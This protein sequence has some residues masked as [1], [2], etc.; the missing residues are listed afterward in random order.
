M[1]ASGKSDGPVVPLSPTNNGETE[2]PAESAEGRGPA[3]RNADQSNLDRTQR[4]EHRRSRGLL[5]VREAARKSRELKFTALLHHLTPELLE[6]SFYELRKNAAVGVDGVTWH[7]YER[8]LEERL[9][10]LHGRI[11]RGAFRATPSKRVYIAKPDGRKRPL[12][13]PSL[14]DKIVQ[15]AVRTVLQCIYEEEFLGFSYGFRPQRSQH[16][17][18]DALYVAITEKRVNWILDAD[19]EGFFDNINRDWLVKFIEHRVGDKRIVRL[20]QKWL[21]AGIIEGT[22]WS[23]N[24]K[25]TPQG[26][27]LSPLLAN[28]FLHYVFD[29]WINQWRS[30]HA[31]GAVTV[32]RYADDF[33]IGFEREADARACWEALA[34]RLSQF[35]LHLHPTK[36]RLIEFGRRSA[37]RREREGQGKCE[38]FDFLGFTHACGKTRRG[39]FALKRITMASRMRRTLAALKV[40]LERCR[41]DPV[42]Q[43]GRWLTSVV[44]GWQGYHAVPDNYARLEQFDKAVTKLWRRQLQ[45]R[46]QR[47]NTRWPW[48]RLSRLIRTYLPRPRILH[49]RP[50]IRHHARLEARAV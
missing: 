27:V 44:R 6:A 35:G 13:I 21:N 37:A 43:V 32:I 48:T 33:V 45:R 10:D 12:G 34:E 36:T 22:D 28:V 42:G 30:R 29:L 8:D 46:S 31:K 47:G 39:W 19:I 23:D 38:T 2:S 50:N 26:A 18:L 5:G 11:H 1:N 49:P 17:A 25:G 15:H 16:Q 41:H 14:E 9:V 7:E 3:R 20:I 40:S 4:P 24:G